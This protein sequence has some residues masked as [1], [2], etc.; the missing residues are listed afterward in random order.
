LFARAGMDVLRKKLNILKRHCEEV[1]R[2][3]DE[4]E[5]T[6]LDT[7]NLAPGNTTAAQ[8]IETCR[9]LAGLGFQ[10][11]IFNMPNVHELRPLEIFG[12]EI[13]PAVAEL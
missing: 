5:R 11:A 3:Y 12:R 7:V 13:I 9:A 8:V 6:T 10:H 2:P 1:G 4:I